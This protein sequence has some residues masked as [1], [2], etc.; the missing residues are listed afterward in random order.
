M[1]RNNYT[2]V[3]VI[4]PS[5]TPYYKPLWTLVGGGQ[6]TAFTTERPEASVMPEGAT[7]IKKSASAFDPDNNTVTCADGATYAYDVLVVSPGIQLDW[8]GTEGRK[9][10]GLTRWSRT[11]LRTTVRL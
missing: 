6:V 1:L 8:D 9:A 7:W 11:N 5:N 3:E 4:E 2:D 10:S